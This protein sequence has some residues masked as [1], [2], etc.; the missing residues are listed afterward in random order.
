VMVQNAGGVAERRVITTGVSDAVNV[1]VLTGL[2][3]G[4]RVLESGPAPPIRN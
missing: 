3:A 1:Q 2:A 4:E